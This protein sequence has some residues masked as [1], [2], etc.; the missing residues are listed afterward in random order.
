M[1]RS[2]VA[3]EAQLGI[4]DFDPDGDGWA[5]VA[6]T[7]GFT[8][9]GPVFSFDSSVTGVVVKVNHPS[10]GCKTIVLSS[11]GLVRRGD[12]RLATVSSTTAGPCT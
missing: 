12:T 10:Q 1:E 3:A 5:L 4:S 6:R 11:L 2:V 7:N 8:D 9:D